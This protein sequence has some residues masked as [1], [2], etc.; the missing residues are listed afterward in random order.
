[1]EATTSLAPPIIIIPVAKRS[2]R[3]GV[4][5]TPVGPAVVIACDNKVRDVAMTPRRRF[6]SIIYNKKWEQFNC[7]HIV[8]TLR[9]LRA[10]YS[11]S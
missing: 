8:L 1:M 10:A 5:S 7:S 2:G 3:A 4:R 11:F 9:R 6:D